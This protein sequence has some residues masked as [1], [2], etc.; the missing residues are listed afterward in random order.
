MKTIEVI[1]QALA[2]PLPGKE[3]QYKLAPSNRLIRDHTLDIKTLKK[4]AVLILL[5]YKNNQLHILLTQRASYVGPHGGQISF[6]GG[7]F[8]DHLDRNLIDTAIRE[9]FEEINLRDSYFEILGPIST[10]N[11]PVSQVCVQPY[12]AYCTDISQARKDDFEVVDLYEVPIAHLLNPK[13]I[14]IKSMYGHEFPYFDFDGK[15][16]WGAT[17]M[18][19]SELLEILK[20]IL[21][22]SG[23]VFENIE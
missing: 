8:E 11:V 17:A 12:L 19:I 4:S 22:L 13:T 14:K 2:N 16:I 3:A 5:F 7:K 20:S 10:L 21:P 15:V 6:P 1:R 9:T 18:I 23:N